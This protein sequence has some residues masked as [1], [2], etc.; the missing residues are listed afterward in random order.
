MYERLNDMLRRRFRTRLEVANQIATIILTAATVVGVCVAIWAAVVLQGAATRIETQAPLVMQ[1][2]LARS[3]GGVDGALTFNGNGTTD[4]EDFP[5]PFK[6]SMH[7]GACKIT[8]YG[9]APALL[10]TLSFEYYR[11]TNGIC[12]FEH[13]QKMS[14]DVRIPGIAAGGTYIVGLSALTSDFVFVF[15]PTS[16]SYQT[17]AEARP[18]ENVVLQF[19]KTSI[20][21][22][23][24]LQKP[25]Y[26][27]PT[28]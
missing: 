18:K 24:H 26:D 13:A 1:C 21:L 2:L 27:Y 14:Q 11:T 19:G 3:P 8:N 22:A 25:C 5:Q 9:R 7:A 10:V 6:P 23:T 15:L 16:A 20:T 28:K 12:G 17:P 4:F